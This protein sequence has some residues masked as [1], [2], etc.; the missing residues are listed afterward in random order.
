MEQSWTKREIKVN[1]KRYALQQT[2]S[3]AAPYIDFE[4]FNIFGG[5]YMTQSSI[6]NGSFIARIISR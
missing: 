4:S 5:L 1:K 3:F 6:Y 2:R